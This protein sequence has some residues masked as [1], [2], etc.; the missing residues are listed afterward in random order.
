VDSGSRL[1][2]TGEGEAGTRGGPAGDLYVV[3]FVKEHD[4]FKR[5]DQDIIIEVP[6]EFP[7]AALGGTVKVPTISGSANLKI[8]AGT[9]NGSVFRLRGKGVPAPPPRGE[10]RGDQLVK[11]HIE[12]QRNLNR[13][14][15]EKLE[16]FAE[17]CERGGGV[18]PTIAK[19][20]QN[21]KQFFKE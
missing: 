7:T 20:L 4:V 19:F 8:P 16:S 11:V 12:V 10:G 5:R 1:L 17:A 9:Q 6:V 14:Q 21:V 18:Y 13:E 2:V 3:L 15:R